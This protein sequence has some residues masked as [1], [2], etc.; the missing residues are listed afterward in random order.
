VE[1]PEPVYPEDKKSSGESARVGLLLTVDETGH[2]S[3]AEVSASAGPEFDQAALAAARGLVFKP[4]TRDGKASPA[5]IPFHFD[6]TFQAPPP[7]EPA[8][9][10]AVA[11]PPA[12]PAAIE[13]SAEAADSLDIDVEGDK[14]PREPTQRTLLVEEITK[15]PGTNGDALRSLTNMPGVA[16]PAAFDGLLIVR[17][18]A[19]QDTQVFV[20][21]TSVPLI[22]HL[23]GLSSVVPSEI[24]ERIDFYPGNFGPQYGRSMGGIV[25]VG[26]R[27]PR[28]D[29]FHGLLQFDSVD[30]RFLAEGPI[31]DSTRVLVAGRRSWLDAW[32][33]PALRSTGVG[34]TVA[35]VYYDYQA[36]IEHDISRNTQLRLFA[37]G[38]D[39]RTELTLNSPDSQDPALGGSVLSREAFWRV[40]ARL[41]TRPTDSLRWTTT[42]S[43]GHNSERQTVGDLFVDVDV[44]SFEG[45]S[46]LRAKLSPQLTAVAGF[47]VQ[48]NYF[49]AKV[50]L[51]PI[52]FG[53][54][55]PSGPLFGR[56]MNTLKASGGVLRPSAYA[57]LEVAP[58]PGLKIFPGVRT[59]YNQD[60]GDWTVDPRVGVRY[61]V[62]PSFPRT[63]LKG[64]VGIF[65]QPPEPYETAKE[66]GTSKLDSN[67]ATHYSLGFEQEFLPPLELSVEGFY[68]DLRKLVISSPSATSNAA[69]QT[70]S[71]TGTGRAYG[72]EVLLRYKPSGPFFGWL[73]YTL[74]RSERRDAAD[75][76]KYLFDYD[77]TH[78]LT[79]LASYKLGRGWQVGARFRYVSG[80]PYTPNLGG[81]MD[82][83]AGVY[84][85]VASPRQNSARLPAFQQLD[86]RVDKTWKFK[87]WSL[88][89]YL[90][91]QNAYNHKNVEAQGDNYDYSATTKIYG[92]PILPIVGLRGEL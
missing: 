13:P 92:L 2:V 36:M 11:P 48:H 44:L 6:F 8:A 16:R 41:D 45:R 39:D 76:A 17:G 27:S 91:I 51:P 82:Y 32:L 33:G 74:S 67:I 73:A 62:H 79:A 88:A 65:H 64:G 15:L 1:A 70:Y 35:P 18:S 71:N 59:D 87:S 54:D 84:S 40:Q 57:M 28:K 29:R 19:P 21:G 50:R 90:D 5:R 25:D 72:A 61:D 4:A 75:D 85:P 43:A 31:T 42:L 63:T 56:P 86:V 89:W 81:V 7:P 10:P 12:P 83:D 20:D 23:G 47:D 68:K 60:T 37:F 53:S 34:V 78:I 9:A 3:Q 58:L 14:P 49:D 26:V 38:A 66:F 24:L 77:Q 80:K 55:E 69:G 22:Y 52:E 30:G 46:D